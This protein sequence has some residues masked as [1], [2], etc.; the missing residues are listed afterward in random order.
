MKWKN[1][2]A[3]CVGKDLWEGGKVIMLCCGKIHAL[4]LWL[5]LTRFIAVRQQICVRERPDSNLY[6]RSRSSGL[7]FVVFLSLFWRMSSKNLEIKHVSP[8]PNSYTLTFDSDI[9]MHTKLHNPV[10]LNLCETA[11]Q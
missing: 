7:G 2:C 3:W 6:H 4:L 9:A 1:D 8:F 5:Y 11:A 10:F